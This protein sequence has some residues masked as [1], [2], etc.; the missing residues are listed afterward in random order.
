M[1]IARFAQELF[2]PD[3]SVACALKIIHD[4]STEEAPSKPPKPNFIP[5]FDQATGIPVWLDDGRDPYYEN[6]NNISYIY[7]FLNKISPSSLKNKRRLQ[8]VDPTT[9]VEISTPPT[10]PS[11][12]QG[13]FPPAERP[14][15]KKTF[16][17]RF[18]Q[19]F[20]GKS[21][22]SFDNFLGSSTT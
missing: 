18:K 3:K 8:T 1:L 17:K 16:F 15:K 20:F 4:T 10:L 5:H 22:S 21:N 2:L 9:L 7:E 6:I 12:S 13:S 11:L 19:N 14:L